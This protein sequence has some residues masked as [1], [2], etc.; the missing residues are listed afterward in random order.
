MSASSEHSNASENPAGWRD[1]LTA[2]RL[3]FT[4]VAVLPFVAGIYLSYAHHHLTSPL[5]GG[6]G[7]L[8]V[9]LICIG[10]YLTGEIFDQREDLETI[11]HGRTRFSGGTLV[12]ARGRLT[13]NRV[14]LSAAAT[15]MVAAV[16]GV[17]IV[18]VHGNMVLLGLGAFGMV[19]A[20]AYSTPPIRL[21]KRGLGE[22]FIAICYGWLTLV[23]G[24]ASASGE[25][26]PHS[27]L[28]AIPVS[29][30]V[31]NVIFLNEFPDYEADRST[32]KRNLLVRVGQTW[33]ARI[34]AMASIGT[35]LSMLLLWHLFS[36]TGLNLIMVMPAVVLATWL[37]IA[38]GVM[39]RWRSLRT[40]E[41]LC[42]ATI[43]LNLLVAV[44]L[45][46]VIRW[47]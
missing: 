16:L 46:V 4:S 2:I 40:V 45:A 33:G 23:T 47:S 10:C 3:P 24:Y 21:V 26:L 7:V 1:W 38:I 19:S 11:R 34:Y 25:L 8:A 20:I 28:L 27:A 39:N 5:A 44:T 17:V 32:G 22:L 14:A 31:F 42:G 41:P 18:T 13:A 15:F 9:L 6:L 12:V 35:A 43:V 36:G 37:A 29:L 30:T